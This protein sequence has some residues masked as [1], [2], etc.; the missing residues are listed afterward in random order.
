MGCVL[1][2]LLGALAIAAGAQASVPL[3][4]VPLTLQTFALLVVA[5]IGGSLVGAAAA[6][7][8]ALAAICG[9]PVLASWSTA[10]GLDFFTRPTAGYV[11][12]FIP[13]AA[14][15]G[16]HRVSQRVDRGTLRLLA[17]L[18][19]TMLLGHALIF[20]IGV[21]WLATRVGLSTAIDHGFLPFLPGAAIKSLA[22]A[23]L[24]W[25]WFTRPRQ[26]GPANA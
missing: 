4:P 9:L 14:L 7:V 10:P 13:C 19:G 16:A 17:G 12:G 24:V 11:I 2:V 8:Y 1:K 22:A 5:G 20:A 26:R 25:A 18:G 21:P 15:V 3:H 6:F 23:M